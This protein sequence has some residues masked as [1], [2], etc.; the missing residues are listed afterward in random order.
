MTCGSSEPLA[1]VGDRCCPRATVAARTQRGP[2]SGDFLRAREARVVVLTCETWLIV[3]AE[4]RR[5][6]PGVTAVVRCNLV[7]RGPDV[8]PMWPHQSVD[9][10]Y[11]GCLGYLEC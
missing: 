1:T 11:W 10:G 2:G 4:L 5:C 3:S 6:W 9:Q 7:G 8:A